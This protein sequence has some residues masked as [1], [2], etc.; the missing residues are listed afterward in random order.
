MLD[1]DYSV[2]VSENMASLGGKSKLESL[3]ECETQAQRRFWL[4]ALH[5][6]PPISWLVVFRQTRAG[7]RLI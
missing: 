3:Q 5:T 2:S 4:H 7:E 6:P 1:L